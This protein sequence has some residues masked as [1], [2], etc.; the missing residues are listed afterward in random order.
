MFLVV[1]E[2]TKGAPGD[3]GAPWPLGGRLIR[4]GAIAEAVNQS[5]R[6]SPRHDPPWRIVVLLAGGQ[7]YL[8]AVISTDRAPPGAGTSTESPTFLPI[9][10][11]ARGEV[12]EIDPFFMS[13]SY[14]P[15][16]R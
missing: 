5:P 15:T 8:T 9:S 2:K 11:F 6:P 16:M 4:G 12:T 13:A 10:A 14:W 7:A 1:G 3:P